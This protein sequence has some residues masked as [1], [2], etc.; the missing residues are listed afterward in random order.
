M[1]RPALFPP[2]SIALAFGLLGA[3]HAAHAQ[4][5]CGD[6]TFQGQCDG[7]VLSFCSD[8][9][10]VALD[11]ATEY[12][13]TDVTAGICAEIDTAYGFDCALPTGSP[14]VFDSAGGS[15]PTFCAEPSDA[16]VID[17]SN[18]AGFVCTAG[19]AAC[20]EA[21]PGEDYAPSCAGDALYLDCLSGAQPVAIDC[22]SVG[23]TCADAACVVGEGIGCD[24]DLFRC[25]TGFVC[26]GYNPATGDFG[27][28]VVA[29]TPTETCDG[30][31][32][33]GA[34]EGS[35]AVYC[36]D[37][38]ANSNAE[39]YRLTCGALEVMQ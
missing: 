7:A 10:L 17:F 28:C 4:A 15:I 1:R 36:S 3:A 30:V 24:E 38:N 39:L 5:E 18:D 32:N 2:S 23:G 33:F 6:I 11:C 9:Q 27:T 25:G 8:A 35:D 20:T 13:P 19:F 37:A 14:C 29:A 22:G 16:C 12:F 31:T 26:E 34:C 21:S